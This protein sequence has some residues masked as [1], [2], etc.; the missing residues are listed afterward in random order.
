[1]Q[2]SKQ[3][4]DR[5]RHHGSGSWRCALGYDGTLL[6]S[7]DYHWRSWRDMLAQEGFTLTYEE[8]AATFGQ[9]NDAILRHL[10]GADLPAEEIDRIGEA[11]EVAYRELVRT[12]GVELLPGIALWLERLQQAGW[13]QAVASSAPRANIDVVID[14]LQI[15]SFFCGNCFR[16]GC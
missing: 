13:L 9:R 7:R 11:K 1:M 14:A 15:G 5:S 6:D 12:Q 8:F 2:Q 4:T 16:R 3:T 10:L